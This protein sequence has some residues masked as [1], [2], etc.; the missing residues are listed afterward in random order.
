MLDAHQSAVNLQDLWTILT[1]Y[2][3]N[4]AKRL[5]YTSDDQAL[6]DFVLD[7]KSVITQWDEVKGNTTYLLRTFEQALDEFSNQHSK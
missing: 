2:V 6:L 4:A 5:A 3:D 1:T 7:F